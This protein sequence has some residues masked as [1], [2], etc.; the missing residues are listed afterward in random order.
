MKKHFSHQLRISSLWA[1]MIC[2]A[3]G[4]IAQKGFHSDY[5]K[6]E[7]ESVSGVNII[8]DF[9]LP[10]IQVNEEE[11]PSSAPVSNLDFD[12]IFSD[13]SKVY[14][15]SDEKL[16]KFINRHKYLNRKTETTMGYRV[17]VFTGGRRRDAENARAK[18]IN[19][20]PDI[21]PDF[22]YVGTSYKVRVG[23][24]L[25]EN[26]AEKFSREL[27]LY[28]SQ[29]IVVRDQVKV[30]KYHPEMEMELENGTENPFPSGT[31]RN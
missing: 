18:F 14:I 6:F 13:G 2:S 3:S 19:L 22:N 7:R 15:E 5:Y 1:L 29:A 31:N 28:F 21:R 20:Y 16:E 11:M 4:L 9:I 8:F 24:F 26:D 30:P 25:K 27:K 17:Q 10:E 23:D 12:R